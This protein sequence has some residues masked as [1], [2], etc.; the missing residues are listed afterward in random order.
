[1][2]LIT[3]PCGTPD[4]TVSSYEWLPLMTMLCSLELRMER[5]YADA[6]MNAPV[7]SKE[8]KL[9]KKALMWHSFKGLAE[10]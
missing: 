9:L 10:I 8:L 5:I 3:V 6:V 4:K 1:M 2:A 7:D